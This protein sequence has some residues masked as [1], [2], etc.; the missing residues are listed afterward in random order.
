MDQQCQVCVLLSLSGVR[1]VAVRADGV[2]GCWGKVS[3][4]G[5]RRWGR[6]GTGEGRRVV[7]VW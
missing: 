7:V 2:S 6:K 3:G 5:E 1:G 4:Q